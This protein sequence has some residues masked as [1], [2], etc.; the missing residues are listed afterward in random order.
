MVP[1]FFILKM[2]LIGHQIGGLW[3]HNGVAG[4]FRE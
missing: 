1:A 3:Q 2:N 4:A